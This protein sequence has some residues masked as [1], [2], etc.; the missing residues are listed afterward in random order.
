MADRDQPTITEYRARAD[1]AAAAL[2]GA[3]LK[4]RAPLEMFTAALRAAVNVLNGHLH[5]APEV[6]GQLEA[7]AALDLAAS[8]VE[9]GIGTCNAALLELLTASSAISDEELTGASTPPA[10]QMKLPGTTT[11]KGGKRT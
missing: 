8:K 2:V 9:D 6:T 4:A 3:V 7:L 5:A 1:Q 11:P 10:R